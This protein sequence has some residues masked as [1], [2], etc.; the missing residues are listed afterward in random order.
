VHFKQFK[1]PRPQCVK[2][3]GSCSTGGREMTASFWW[4]KVKEWD[5]L[6][7][8]G[9]DGTMILKWLLKKYDVNSWTGLVC[10]KMGIKWCCC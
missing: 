10:L 9:I 8:L 3:V 4:R 5:Y 2:V 7:D 1:C 6:E